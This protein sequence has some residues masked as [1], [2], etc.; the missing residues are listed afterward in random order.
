MEKAYDRVP[1]GEVWRC[2]RERKVSEKYVRLVQDVYEGATT[3]ARSSVGL[4][5]SFPVGVGLH[6]GSSLS[7]YIFDLIMDV[8]GQNIIASAPWDMRMM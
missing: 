7:P 3:Q 1:R 5:E 6:Q 2:L 4:T 8:L